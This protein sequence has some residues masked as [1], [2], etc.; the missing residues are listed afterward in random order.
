MSTS[1]TACRS[2]AWRTGRLVRR[3][4]RLLFGQ[5]YEDAAIETALFPPGG[6]IFCIASAGCTSLT[7]AGCGY[8]VTAVDLNP[9]QVDYLRARLDGKGTRQGE[10]ERLLSWGRRLM[11]LSGLSRSER[12]S[13]L[14]LDD[15]A[16][17][18]EQWRNSPSFRRW[19]SALQSLLG[20]RCMGRTFGPDFVRWLPR[21]FPEAVCQRL[22]RGFATHPNCRNPFAWRLLLGH[23]RQPDGPDMPRG[24]AEL[25]TLGCADAVEFLEAC[26][27]GLF[28]GFHLSNILDGA[29]VGY[30]NRLCRAVRH[31][32][33][34]W[35]RLVLR[36][37][38][39]PSSS[40]QAQWAQLDR[41]ML[42]GTVRVQ[43]VHDGP[44]SLVGP[45]SE[46]C[47]IRE[48]RLQLSSRLHPGDED[49]DKVARS[50]TPGT[51]QYRPHP[52][53]PLLGGKK[54]PSVH[55]EGR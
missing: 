26:P 8:R 28:D 39:Q 31:A 32:G 10:I 45:F 34:P 2:T 13:F 14:K 25:W 52:E 29:D 42:W 49:G 6:H 50:S 36:S 38:A 33:A 47:A 51:C 35:A 11:S 46:E 22:E 15:T 7:L 18:V 55:W 20:P 16:Q 40:H 3:P 53:H 54:G 43:T 30:A 5:M 19:R 23:P 17:Q 27:Q 37:L 41:S 48:I 12:H 24:P 1:D 4:G 9:A 44:D 21:D